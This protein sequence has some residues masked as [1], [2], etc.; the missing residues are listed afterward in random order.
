MRQSSSL[1][2]P[3]L[4]VPILSLAFAYHYHS[5]AYAGVPVTPD[6]LDSLT[7][8]SLDDVV[9]KGIKDQK[10][11][12]I[13][14]IAFTSIGASQLQTS[15]VTSLKEV[16]G[17]VPNFIMIDRDTPHTSSVIVRGV[18]S[19]LRPAVVM[20]VDGVPHFEKSTFDITM[21]DVER[22]VFLRGPQGTAFGR[23]AMGGV[24]LI[25]TRSPFKYQGTK[26][27]VGYG[28]FDELQ[29]NLSHLDRVS[30]HLAYS[31]SGNYLHN[32]GFLTNEY[33]GTKADRADKG[34]I[35]GKLEF[36]P[37]ANTLFRLTQNL[38]LVRQGAY[39]YGVIE[40]GQD[41]VSTVNLNHPSSYTRTMYDGGLSVSHHTP[42]F[43]FKGQVSSHIVDAFYDID[44][45]GT[46]EEGSNV[47]QTE[48]QKLFSEEISFE[49]KGDGWYQWRFGAFAFQHQIDRVADVDMTKPHTVFIHRLND[50]YT[51]GV[52]AY[53]ESTF[54]IS[55]RFKVVGGLR[56]DY[57][58]SRLIY[59]EE[60]GGK[61]RESDS[62]LRF[63]QLTPK[64]S[65]QYFFAPSYQLYATASKGYITGGF[66]TVY[67][68]DDY[69]TFDAEHSWNYEVGAKG[70]ML[71]G[72][73]YSELVLFL[74]D[75]K[76]KQLNKTLG[77]IGQ[78]T[79]NAGSTRSVGVEASLDAKVSDRWNISGSYGFTKAQFT[80]YITVKGDDYKGKYL[81][82]VP[83]HTVALNTQYVLPLKSKWINRAILHVGYKGIG[84][85][86]W[87]EDNMVKQ[88]FYNL[89]DASLS[90]K[91]GRVTTSIWG[92]NILNTKYLGYFY[93]QSDRNMGK[94]G[95]P[96]KAGVSV[97]VSL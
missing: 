69:R 79:Y 16:T 47:Q 71:P 1:L 35:S 34:A 94:P 73:V 75:T 84:D 20:Y 26:V 33:D 6:S 55:D 93:V 89:L 43:I 13:A 88:K 32:G 61:I 74:V 12:S 85:M 77:G 96:I 4:L 53:H 10:T 57:E 51:W 11:L 64:V 5:K 91:S 46:K 17:L 68:G 48:K 42:T 59:S 90:V 25:E 70:E 15:N 67:V 2:V 21:N 22:I 87:H 24:M 7:M 8:Y 66:N 3:K 82:F 97:E 19:K 65:M 37:N 80:D 83:R 14:P 40:D 60:K 18:G 56:Y 36:S 31:V 38:D 45:D 95:A 78:V 28:R 58:K 52:A 81:P 62:D 76:G 9:V 72:R 44:Q 92:S 63:V 29:L 50:N 39:T 86:Y 54:N 23:N 30:E 27:R 49:G 41:H